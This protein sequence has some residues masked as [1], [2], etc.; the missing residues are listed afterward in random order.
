MPKTALDIW[1]QTAVLRRQEEPPIAC[2]PMVCPQIL[3]VKPSPVRDL[4]LVRQRYERLA[5]EMAAVLTDAIARASW[6]S[7]HRDWLLDA[8]DACLHASLPWYGL[9]QQ[10]DHLGWELNSRKV[11]SLLLYPSEERDVRSCISAIRNASRALRALEAAE[12]H[13]YLSQIAPAQQHK[14]ILALQAAERHEYER[15]G[16]RRSW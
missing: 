14:V 12:R 11:Q 5:A 1:F 6:N 3:D 7:V 8:E 2:R 16:Q 4:R 15:R 10:A 9:K 13:E